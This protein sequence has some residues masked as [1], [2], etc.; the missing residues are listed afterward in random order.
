M[1]QLKMIK[2]TYEN[3]CNETIE[4]KDILSLSIKNK[5]YKLTKPH[6]RFLMYANFIELKIKKRN[7]LKKDITS[8]SLIYDDG[9]DE[10]V[11]INWSKSDAINGFSKSQQ[12]NEEN[13][14]YCWVFDITNKKREKNND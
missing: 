5:E 6:F 11:F 2:V 9:T 1:K 12:I 10:V 8:L 14:C 13:E 3:C 7:I 4:K